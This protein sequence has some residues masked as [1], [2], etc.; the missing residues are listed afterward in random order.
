MVNHQTL[1]GGVYVQRHGKE[2]LRGHGA[3]F[4]GEPSVLRGSRNAITEERVI[5]GRGARAPLRFNMYTND[6]SIHPRFVYKDAIDITT[7]SAGF[8]SIEDRGSTL[9]SA[10]IGSHQLTSREPDKNAKNLYSLR[11]HECGKQFNMSWNGVSL[12]QLPGMYL[13]VTLDRTLS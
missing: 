10:P 6:R 1:L 7:P 8:T 3:Q 12:V 5:V 9:I 13:G 11:I 2:P 4:T